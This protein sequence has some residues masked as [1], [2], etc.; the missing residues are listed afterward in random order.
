MSEQLEP[1]EAFQGQPQNPEQAMV[2]E[3]LEVFKELTNPEAI[4]ARETWLQDKLSDESTPLGHVA[5]LMERAQ[6]QHKE[7]TNHLI[8]NG[9]DRERGKKLREISEQTKASAYRIFG[10]DVV[11][12]YYRI[13]HALY[14]FRKN[15]R[16]EF[17]G[18]E[19]SQIADQL[20]SGSPI[21]EDGIDRQHVTP[22]VEA[23]GDAKDDA[24]RSYLDKK[25]FIRDRVLDEA[26]AGQPKLVIMGQE[27]SVPTANIVSA[28]D[29]ASWKGRDWD[30]MGN[31]SIVNR[32]GQ[33][34][35]KPSFEVIKDYAERPTE[36]P[37]LEGIHA[38]I[39]PNGIV[40]YKASP[41]NHRTAAAIARGQETVKMSGEIQVFGL[42]RNLVTA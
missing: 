19:A 7:G 25:V 14:E 40:I 2:P 11:N 39:Q 30:G 28:S 5:R 1:A 18:D 42:D 9:G 38:Y 3:N 6:L 21:V 16:Y 15:G 27:I 10:E 4:Q 26:S 33:A 12:E 8:D 24:Y 37:P 36:L 32:D 31:K 20:L 22:P 35:T 17:F 23:E 34:V 29:F 41:S 13:N